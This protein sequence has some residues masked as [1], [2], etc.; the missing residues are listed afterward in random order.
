MNSIRD[1]WEKY[2]VIAGI[3][4]LLVDTLTLIGFASSYVKWNNPSTSEVIVT[5]G[6]LPYESNRALFALSGAVIII[7]FFAL[8][9]YLPTTNDFIGEYF[10]RTRYGYTYFGGIH[11]TMYSLALAIPS[12]ILWLRVFFLIPQ[13]LALTSVVFLSSLILIAL[14]S[15]ASFESILI[16]I[17]TT[18]V[19]VSSI[20]AVFVICII[21]LDK[22]ELIPAI[23]MASAINIAVFSYVTI[24]KSFPTLILYKVYRSKK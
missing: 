23:A 20:A 9:D 18:L 13:D 10:G 4:G 12:I 1:T 21:L 3:V 24:M 19:V 15:I 11:S 16:K 5:A 17:N 14:C 22:W 8:C 6:K 7:G 2:G